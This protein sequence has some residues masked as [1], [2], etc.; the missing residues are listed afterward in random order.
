MVRPRAGET[1]D[2]V[3]RRL[4]WRAVTLLLQLR[5]MIQSIRIRGFRSLRDVTWAPGRLNVII[6]PNG[7]GK[8]NLLRALLLLQRSATGHL[9]GDIVRLGGIA[10]L[11]WDGQSE[12]IEWTIKT[13]PLE[14]TRDNVK[15]ALTYELRLRQLGKTNA[16]RIEHELLANY[17]LQDVGKRLTPMKFLERDARHAVTFD[18]KSKKLV[19]PE[20]AVSEDQPLLSIIG[21]PSPGNPIVAAFRERVAAWGIYHDL[22]VDQSAPIRQAAVTKTERRVAADGQ[23]LISVLH[24]LYTDPSSRDFKDGVDEALRAAFGPDYDGLSFPPA[25]DHRVQLRLAWRSLRTAQSAA[26]LSDGTIRFLLLLAVL[27]NPGPDSLVAID[28]PETGLHPG[29]LP[30]VAELARQASLRC[31]VI[32]TTHSPQFLEGFR[33]QA[34]TTTIAQ[35]R[36]GETTLTTL[37]PGELAKW[38][39]AYSLCVVSCPRSWPLTELGVQHLPTPRA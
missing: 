8:S 24:T 16:Y 3:S 32:F 13:D 14:S 27:A 39:K 9:P 12:P 35:W 36:E 2:S 26:E 37:D 5:I 22:H 11:Q 17:H 15:D 29:M 20:G 1:T 18:V 7:V 33:D 28:E 19:T 34:P 6:G 30:V 25:A 21:G 31:Q 10:P 38:R 4:L 23:N